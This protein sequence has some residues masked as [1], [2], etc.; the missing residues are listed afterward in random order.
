MMSPGA[1]LLTFD[2]LR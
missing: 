2:Y 1:A